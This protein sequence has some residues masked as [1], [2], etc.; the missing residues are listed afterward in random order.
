MTIGEAKEWIKDALNNINLHPSDVYEKIILGETLSM[1]PYELQLSKN[2]RISNSKKEEITSILER[3]KNDEPIQYIIGKTNFFGFEFLINE[4]VLIPR[5]ETEELVEWCLQD[6]TSKK[7]ILDIGSGSGCIAI[8]LALSNKNFIVDTLEKDSN[9]SVVIKENNHQLNAGLNT[10]HTF[11]FLNKANWNALLDYDI[12]ISNPPYIPYTDVSLM[13]KNVLEYEP[14]LALFVEN[15]D[16][17]IFYRNILEFSEIHLKPNGVIYFE[18][19]EDL[20]EEMKML[21]DN[22]KMKCELR[23]DLQGK[24][25]MLK[26]IK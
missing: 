13:H 3:L 1:K 5:P 26:V 17:L 22:F 6:N 11:D 4:N 9:A 16:P 19:H 8:S 25:R 14:H 15:N 18:I 2:E 12:I 20:G 10:I 7:S 23:K 21:C 24:D